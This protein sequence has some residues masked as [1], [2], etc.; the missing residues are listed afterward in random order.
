MR[1]LKSFVLDAM[2]EGHPLREVILAEKDEL[3]SSDFLAKLEN[4]NVLIR[5]RNGG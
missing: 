2:P 3:S 5:L 4:W 1:P